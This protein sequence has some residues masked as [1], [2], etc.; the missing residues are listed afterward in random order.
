MGKCLA[1]LCGLLIVTVGILTAFEDR[2]FSKDDATELLAKSGIT[3]SDPFEI[4][5]N[6]S[7]WAIGDYYHTF[8]IHISERDRQ[9]LISEIKHSNN[10]K[11][12]ESTVRDLL[13]ERENR[14]SGPVRTQHYE[15]P[16]AYVRE[17]FKP[18]GE[19]YAPTFIRISIDKNETVLIFE[20]IVE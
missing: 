3:L 16:T 1:I 2:F 19:G 13:F 7:S 20:D 18:N 9:T 17:Y 6:R 14:Y 12:L 15:T 8:T 10:F 5:D 4:K 11:K